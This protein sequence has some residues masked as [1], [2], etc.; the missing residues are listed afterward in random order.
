MTLARQPILSSLALCFFTSLS[1][2]NTALACPFAY[3]CDLCL[4]SSTRIEYC[5]LSRSV[6][7]K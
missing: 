3:T 1:P 7:S 6:S 2:Y 4:Q 5:H